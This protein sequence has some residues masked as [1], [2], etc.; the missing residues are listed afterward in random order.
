MTLSGRLFY[1]MHICMMTCSVKI[2]W[3][4]CK[5][6]L[7]KLNVMKMH[8]VILEIDLINLHCFNIRHSF[9]TLKKCI[10][11]D[12][13]WKR[14]IDS[15]TDS[16]CKVEVSLY[17]VFVFF[18]FKSWKSWFTVTTLFINWCLGVCQESEFLSLSY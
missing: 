4:A 16:V 18:A 9:Y 6:N 17:S 1:G 15:E 12:F 10:K 14:R 8:Q 5:L 2:Y 13:M 7:L 11:S 3:Y